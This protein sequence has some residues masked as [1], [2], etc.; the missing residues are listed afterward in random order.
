MSTAPRPLRWQKSSF[1]SNGT[2]CVEIAWRK[3]SFSSNGTS[4]VEVAS[5][6]VAV[7][8]SK[9]P[10]GPVLSVDLRGLLRMIKG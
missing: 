10:D 4:C 8:D 9:N 1:S 3:S 6:L 2:N 5:H 7:R